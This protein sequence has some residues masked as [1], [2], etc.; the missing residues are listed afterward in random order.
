MDTGVNITAQAGIDQT[1]VTQIETWA[2][3]VLVRKGLPPPPPYARIT[4][5]KTMRQFEEFYRKERELL[6]GVVGE[7]M[8]FLATHDA[9]RGYPSINICQERL[10]GISHNVT[11]GVVHHEISHA[12]HHGRPEFYIFRF[13]QRLQEVGRSHGMDLPLLQQCVYVLS[14]AIKDREAVQWL[15]EIGLGFSQ[16]ALLEHI[17]SDTEQEHGIWEEVRSSPALRTITLG[18]ILK[19]LLPIEAMIS[20]GVDEAQ[21]LRDQWSKAYGWL[22]ERERQGL[23]RFARR[24]LNDEGGSF[25]ERLEQAA[26]RLITDSSL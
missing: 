17:I 14:V 9:W 6:G 10:T 21:A 12:L 26:L 2:N 4:I 25:Q 13:S 8:D 7:E 15:A 5:W 20:V 11:Q 3:E 18:A 19:A 16:R 1:L 22:S 24:T 23:F